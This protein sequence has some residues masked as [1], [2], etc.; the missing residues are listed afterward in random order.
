MDH[1]IARAATADARGFDEVEDAA[2]Q[3]RGLPKPD[4]MGLRCLEVALATGEGES[5]NP[6][7]EVEATLAVA[8]D[9][10]D[11]VYAV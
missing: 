8:R 3:A 4:Q 7:I 6:G 11:V 1:A 10:G 2:G 9:S 5:Q